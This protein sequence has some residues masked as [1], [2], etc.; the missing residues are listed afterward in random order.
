MP[1][2]ERFNVIVSRLRGL[3]RF[4]KSNAALGLSTQ[5]LDNI[6]DS[7]NCLQFLAHRILIATCSELR[8]FSAF[9]TW[10][11][12]EI[13][14][15][16]AD[17]TSPSAQDAVEKDG[18]I[19]HARTLEYI[20]GAMMQSQLI[21]FFNM[22][23][24]LDKRL[25]WDLAAEGRSLYEL[26]KR[27]LNEFSQGTKSDK[28]LP[29]LDALIAHLDAQCNLVSGRIAET[30]RRN[31]RFGAPIYLGNWV[32]VCKDMRMVNEV[33]KLPFAVYDP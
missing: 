17:S 12:Q 11:R 31:V 27:E 29:G 21:G 6:L 14:T 4:Q 1:A 10:L 3:S 2:L 32:P 33:S 15:Q 16:A 24:Q 7:V 8:Q 5:E 30:Q 28:Q 13:D 18:L 9:S 25:K 19:D 20:G 23:P 22:Q 26:Y